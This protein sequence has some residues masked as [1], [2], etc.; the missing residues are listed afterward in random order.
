MHVR[1]RTDLQDLV[2]MWF[3]DFASQTAV[4][5][6]IMDDWLIRLGAGLLE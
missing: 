2:L 4:G 6:R 1:Q 5:D 3:V